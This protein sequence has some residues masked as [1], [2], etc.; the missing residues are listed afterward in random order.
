MQKITSENIK[1]VEVYNVGFGKDIVS[2]S[3]KNRL[4]LPYNE[5]YG[6]PAIRIHLNGS[7]YIKTV[8]LTCGKDNGTFFLNGAKM[9]KNT[10]WLN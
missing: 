9:Q 4:L 2:S 1:S 7:Q 5:N 10:R 8:T 3:T 6:D